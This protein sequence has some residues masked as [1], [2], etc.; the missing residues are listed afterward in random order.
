MS[1]SLVGSEMCIRD[2]LCPG[3]FQAIPKQFPN[4]SPPESASVLVGSE[5][6]PSTSL[7]ESASVLPCPPPFVVPSPFLFP[8]YRPVLV[9]VLF[10]RLLT[11]P[12]PLS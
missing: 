9:S 5:Q 12:F 11:S 3:W 7:P 2:S 4:T 8:R 6:F 10:P 1:A